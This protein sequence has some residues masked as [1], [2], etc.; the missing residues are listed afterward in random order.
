MIPASTFHLNLHLD[1]AFIASC[2]DL[3]R[4]LDLRHAGFMIC[5][6]E[7]LIPAAIGLEY[8]SLDVGS[9]EK[10]ILA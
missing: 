9:Y 5:I 1:L 3:P 10:D 6:G 7:F 8:A 2:P 4:P